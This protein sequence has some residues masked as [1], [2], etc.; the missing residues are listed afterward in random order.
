MV[1]QHC[2]S[3]SMPMAKPEDFPGSDMT[4]DYCVHCARPDGS[5]KSYD[6]VL[7]RL[8][9]FILKMHGLSEEEARSA[10]KGVMHSLPAWHKAPGC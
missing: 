5:M 7:A 9:Q 4:K 1:V 10:A 8:T 3:C 6:E 2:I